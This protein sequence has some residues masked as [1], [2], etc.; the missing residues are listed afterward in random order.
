M[1]AESAPAT[2][3][4]VSL[5]GLVNVAL[6]F[7]RLIAWT[8]GSLCLIVCV[9]LLLLPRTF[10]S[11][12]SFVPQ[13]RR[14][15]AS[16]S[17][18]A[19]QLG[20][21]PN[22]DAAQSPAFYVSLLDSRAILDAVVQT[23]F[24]PDSGPARDLLQVYKVR[25]SSPE[26]KVE[27]AV[28]RLR[29]RL[30]VTADA[31]TGIVMFTVWT[32]DPELSRQI[33]SRLLELLN[34]FNLLS[35]QS[36]AAAERAF[37]EG[38]LEEVGRDLRASEDKLLGFLQRNRD[39]RNA[40][41]LEFEQQRLQQE[42]TMQRQLFTTLQQA[43]EQAKIEEVRDTPVIS[44]VERPLAPATPDPRGLVVKGIIALVL[45]ATLGLLMALALE[46][47]RGP[48]SAPDRDIA[49]LKKLLGE[50]VSRVPVRLR[51]RRK[52]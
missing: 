39:Y 48:A 32:R 36:Q 46:L 17:S 3:E 37:T 6:R 5:V 33:A 50:V 21:L 2:R 34:E 28:R 51:R 1:I 35:R 52:V 26:E 27:R 25:G 19:A 23:S 20:L 11:T 38:R 18:L 24:K 40:S 49:E 8:A 16:I 41:V 22:A 12:A 9:V 44:V 15:N 13:A 10:T 14:T 7:R 31:K 43:F 30:S 42:V 4:A 29:Q 45:G 47:V